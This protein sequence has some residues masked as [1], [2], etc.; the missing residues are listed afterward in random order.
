M[1]ACHLSS[2]RHTAGTNL[3]SR[4]LH[5]A[6]LGNVLRQMRN[7]WRVTLATTVALALAGASAIAFQVPSVTGTWAGKLVTTHDGQTHEDYLHAAIKQN[8]A[9]LTGTAGPDA[10]HQYPIARGKV[11]TEKDVTT[12]AFEVIVNGVHSAFTLKLA[13]GQLKGEARSEEE[14]GSKHLATVELKPVRYG[15]RPRFDS[16]LF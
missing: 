10:D 2:R 12:V 16:D 9:A 7:L 5:F 1:R 15:S 3:L 6:D 4:L 14:D 8:G 13:D 11:T